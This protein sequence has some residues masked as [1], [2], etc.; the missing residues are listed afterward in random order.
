MKLKKI[1]PLAISLSLM[2]GCSGKKQS[3]TPTN[4]EIVTEIKNPV[5]I[6]FW[7]AM[8]GDQEKS[9][10]GLVDNS[11]KSIKLS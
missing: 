8:N 2:A 5:E 3:A 1:L 6:T 4:E 7:H 10:Q 11:S 9:L